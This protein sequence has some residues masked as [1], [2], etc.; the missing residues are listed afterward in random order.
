MNGSGF[1]TGADL[2]HSL[3]NLQI[4][5]GIVFITVM[6]LAAAVQQ[7][8]KLKE[9]LR[10]N[11]ERYR[12]L[13]DTASDAMITIDDTNTILFCNSAVQE[14]FG[15]TKLELIGKEITLLLPDFLKLKNEKIF[16]RQNSVPVK[17]RSLRNIELSGLHKS[18]NKIVLEISLGEFEDDKV[19]FTTVIRD[20]TAKKKT[21]EDNAFLASIVESSN[22]AIIGK[23]KDYKIISWNKGAEKIYGYTADEVIG[24]HVSIIVPEN[25]RDEIETQYKNMLKGMGLNQ[26]ESERICKDGSR[27][28]ISLT[29]SPIMGSEGNIIGASA[30]ERDITDIITAQLKLNNSIKEKDFLLREIHHRVK[31]NFQIISSLLNLQSHSVKDKK[32]LEIFEECQSRI[33]TMSIIHEKLYQSKNIMK[34]NFE[35]YVQELV[36]N[37]VKAYGINETGVEVCYNFSEDNLNID[38]MILLGLIMNEL[39]TNSLKYAFAGGKGKI[40]II[41]CRNASMYTLIIKDNG[42]GLPEDFDPE[43]SASFGLTLVYAFANQ[44]QGDIQITGNS[45]GTQARL[46]FPFD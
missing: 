20:I 40:D 36:S 22:D 5:L 31:N 2:N 13:S 6:P 32:T 34:I 12:I 10:I 44:L 39:L 8:K 4:F 41:F 33:R 19:Q 7:Q 1:F 9:I 46:R 28:N 18:G 26:Y 3:L 27:I 30:I 42:K 25:R 29:L 15:Y 45:G 14:I 11:E 24:K 16:E 23:S 35:N 43:N 38:Q 17:S 21:D 37:L